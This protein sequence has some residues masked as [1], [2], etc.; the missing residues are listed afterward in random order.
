MGA[1]RVTVAAVQGSAPREAGA[2]MLVRT[3]GIEGTIG[4]GAL[5][6]EAM[7]EARRMLAQGQDAAERRL[8]LGPG[9]GQC[10][11]GVV[12]L[13]F[14]RAEG[15]DQSRGV[16]LWVW[17]AGHVGRAIVQVMAP[18]PQ[19][20]VTWADISAA[21]FPQALPDGVIPLVAGNLPR[22]MAHAPGDAL[23]LIM[24]CSHNVDLAL[25]HA[26]LC[27]GFTYCGL[28]GSAT[29]WARFRSRLRSLG[30]TDAE[31]SRITCP[32]GDP[33]LGKHPQAIAVGVA[34]R[35]LI[36]HLLEDTASPVQATGTWD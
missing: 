21:R 6:W 29:K 32:I 9:L 33:T 24:T 25:C 2:A 4:G 18:L 26:A 20:L 12:V 11:G 8:P 34:Q 10:C 14:E 22:L 15:L 30:H 5:E 1:I 28:I 35:L 31:I 13:R 3:D 17:G 23:H 36:A 19:V 27:R 7:A 16:P